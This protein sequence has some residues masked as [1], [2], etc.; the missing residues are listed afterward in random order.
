MTEAPDI[1]VA[2]RTATN[3]EPGSALET[4]DL[5]DADSTPTERQTGRGPSGKLRNFKAMNETKLYDAGVSGDDECDLRRG[6]WGRLWWGSCSSRSPTMSDR[7]RV[8]H[9]P[10]KAPHR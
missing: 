4:D 7:P 8:Q 1:L 3:Y 2:L 6:Q 5:L 9:I 10:R